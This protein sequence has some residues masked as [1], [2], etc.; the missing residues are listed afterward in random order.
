M[1]ID[2]VI[3]IPSFDDITCCRCIDYGGFIALVVLCAA[4]RTGILQAA[5]TGNSQSSLLHAEVS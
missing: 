3:V 4:E 1:V 5:A 2:A